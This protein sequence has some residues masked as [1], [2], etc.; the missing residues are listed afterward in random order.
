MVIFLET[1][2][3][4]SDEQDCV[5]LFQVNNATDVLGSCNGDFSILDSEHVVL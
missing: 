5:G 1:Y 4:S 3:G 2:V